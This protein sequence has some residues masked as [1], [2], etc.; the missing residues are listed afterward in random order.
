MV[1]AAWPEL[2][3]QDS[4]LN[5]VPG[6]VQNM[7]SKSLCLDSGTL[8]ACLLLSPT[9]DELIPKVQEKVLLTFYF[10]FFQ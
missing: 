8:S 5:S 7:L 10:A 3:L 6:Q 2:T 9:V 4:G 1:K